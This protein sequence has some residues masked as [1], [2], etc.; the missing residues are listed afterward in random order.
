MKKKKKGFTLIELLAIIV[1]LAIIAVITVPIILNIIENSKRGAVIDSAYGYKDSIN[2]YYVTE[3]AKNSNFS[4]DGEYNV[5]NDGSITSTEDETKNFPISFSGIKPS[6]GNVTIED[7][8][9]TGACLVIDDYK[10]ELKDG[11]FTTN[12]KGDC[13]GSLVGGNGEEQGDDPS[14]ISCPD[15]VQFN[16]EE[17]NS[18]ECIIRAVQNGEI[19]DMQVGNTKTITLEGLGTHTLRI[20]NMSS[21]GQ[22]GTYGFSETACGFVLEFADI[23]TRREMNTEDTNEGG[24]KDSEMRKY[25]NCSDGKPIIDNNSDS[26]LNCDGFSETSKIYDSLPKELKEAIIDTKVVSGYSSKSGDSDNFTTTDKI[27]LLSAAEIYGNEVSSFVTETDKTRQ[28][29]YYKGVTRDDCSKAIKNGS[30]WWLRTAD[31][32]YVDGFLGITNFGNWDSGSSSYTNDVSPAF[33]IGNP[34]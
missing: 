5:G 27:Y 3:L 6:G 13:N 22:C 9:V 8:V 29:D 17:Q 4:L 16:D 33:R 1:I 24:W 2:K 7:S 30:W 19:S 34:E 28:L 25:L 20:A 10:V 11:K 18:W 32:S 23:V 21:D 31:S 12:G 14:V 26:T 15:T